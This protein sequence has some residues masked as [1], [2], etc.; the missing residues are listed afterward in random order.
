MRVP[1]GT[2]QV[3]GGDQ[4]IA[5]LAFG[6]IDHLEVNTHALG[7]RD[8][9]MIAVEMILRGRKPDAACAVV[10]VDRI[11]RIGGKFTVELD[12][13]GLEPHHGLKA[14]KIGDLRCRMP[15]GAGGQFVTLQ[16]HHIRPA[17]DRQMIQSR[18][19]GN[20]APNHH[21]ARTRLHRFAP[22][23]NA[24]KLKVQTVA[25]QATSPC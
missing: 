16:H 13:M 19:P 14:A 1:Q 8:K 4:R 15:C 20:A 2:E 18:A 10:I 25:M 23:I 6:C 24:G 17:L 22:S 11:F 9:M 7:L 3:V 21:H 5:L 12:G